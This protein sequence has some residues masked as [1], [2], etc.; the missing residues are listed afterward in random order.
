MGKVTSFK[1][2]QVINTTMEEAWSF[3]SDP[4]NLPKLT[5]EELSFKVISKFHGEKMYAG[6]V[7]EYYVRPVLNIPLYWMTEITQVKHHEY[8]IDEQR[9]G[10][11]SF[12]HHQHHFRE[13]TTGVEM[14]DIVHYKLPFWFIGDIANDWFV[15]KQLANIFGYRKKMVEE[16]F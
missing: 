2:V 11:Y 15:R 12:W 5:P 7:I 6:Q 1:T 3:F 8:F 16:M 9:F 13:V 14:T 10:P 4:A